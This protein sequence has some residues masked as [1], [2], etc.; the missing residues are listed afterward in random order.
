MLAN[1]VHT[2]LRRKV[3]GVIMRGY[4]NKYEDYTFAGF[5]GV[6]NCDF[7][8]SFT[9]VNEWNRPDGGFVFVCNPCQFT[10]RFPEIGKA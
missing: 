2:R 4:I 8:D 9:H 3:E 10:K 1:L 5:G 6:D 7:C